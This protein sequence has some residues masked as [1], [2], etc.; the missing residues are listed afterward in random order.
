MSTAS[1]FAPSGRRAWSVRRHLSIYALALILPV[2][3]FSGV[4]LWQF[5]TAEQE[6][7]ERDAWDAARSVAAVIDRDLTGLLA[8]LDV[9]ALTRDLQTGDFE[10]FHAKSTEIQR[11]HGIN[12]LLRDLSGQQ[13]LNTRRPWGAPLPRTPVPGLDVKVV[14]TKRSHVSDLINGVV[15]QTYI[16]DV[17]GPVL[18]GEEVVYL[19]NLSLTPDRL[20]RIIVDEK[21]P[22]NWR[23][24]IIDGNGVIMARNVGQEEFVGQK[25]AADFLANAP[26]REG[27]WSGRTVEG[28]AVVG[29]YASSKLSGWRV[30]IAVTRADLNAPLWRSLAW[31]A[32]LGLGLLA[33]STVLALRFGWRI[34]RPIQALERS[35]EALGRGDTVR[36]IASPLREVNRVG[37]ALT[38]SASALGART[39]ELSES[40]AL[41]GAILESA[42][43]CVIALRDDGRIVEWNPAAERT[44]GYAREEALG[45]P[46][47][48]LI[49]P[50]GVQEGPESL[51]RY[52]STVLGQ[53]IE[54]EGLRADGSRFP[55]ELAITV[56][57]VEAKTH[58]TA[59]LRDITERKRAQAELLESNEEIQRF[60]YIVSHDLRAPLV[61]IMGF[62][63]ELEALRDDLFARLREL[64]AAALDQKGDA[65]ETLA[66][67]FSEALGF[68]KASI[69][70]M[71]RLI[72]AILKLSREGG[73]TFKPERVEMRA[74]LNGIAA[75]LA[76]QADAT[77]ATVEVGDLP[78]LVSDRLA[79]EQMFSNLLDNALKY[80]RPG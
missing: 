58:F 38:A 24:A 41:K 46:L 27:T 73:R 12:V 8:T 13:I 21:I 70:K 1:L 62:T 54:L 19:L 57:Q 50:P 52:L 43:D 61:N 47:A 68:I 18:N 11:R 35:A 49:A 78:S 56:A 42:L 69:A 64:R 76:H 15:A 53:R 65:D 31:F 74:L 9:L 26:G 39:A 71:D 5:T 29:F 44:F 60:A 51:I 28:F 40:E 7:L 32:S 77:G 25:A 14:A 17:E 33:L 80:L 37:D 63:S 55:L 72:N 4:L 10:S 30:G 75:S 79:L 48:D 20:Q 36:P 22:Q 3:S 34:T 59:Y 66:A 23:V 2:L 6:R 16:F 67:D 45:R